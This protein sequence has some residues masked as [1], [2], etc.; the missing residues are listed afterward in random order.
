[1]N[2]LMSRLFIPILLY[3][4][5]YNYDCITYKRIEKERKGLGFTHF[6]DLISICESD[7]TFKHT[8]HLQ[9]RKAGVVKNVEEEINIG[10]WH[11]NK[12]TLILTH[13]NIEL[14][15][16]YIIGRNRLTHV[17]NSPLS[18]KFKWKYYSGPYSVIK[19]KRHNR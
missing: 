13:S 1:M 18:G 15:N 6:Q 19:K 12:D 4:V 8:I 11:I 16:K 5:V 2:I 7:S 17:S 9:I 10:K 14:V 3:S